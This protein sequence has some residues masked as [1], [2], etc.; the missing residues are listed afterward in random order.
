MSCIFC[1]IAAGK[2]KSYKI[3]ENKS[4]IAILDNAP[5][6]NGHTLIISKKHYPDW[7]STPLNVL[8]D[9]VDLSVEMADKLTKKLKPW[10][11]NYISNQGKIASQAILHVHFHV[12]PKYA[13][14]QG[15][16]LDCNRVNIEDVE[17]IAKKLKA[18]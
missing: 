12:I 6:A 4:A 11:F 10:G 13:A 18:K 14:G 8:H 17:K 15:F 3:G 7:Q 1:D 2:I 9:M 16:R 5:L